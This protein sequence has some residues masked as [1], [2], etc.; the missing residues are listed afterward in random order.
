MKIFK[1]IKWRLQIWYGL[2]LVI[3]LAGFGI[4]AY[5]LERNRQFRQIDDE[6]HRRVGVLGNALHRP[7]PRRSNEGERPFDGPPPGRDSG[8]ETQPESSDSAPNNPRAPFPTKAVQDA[9]ERQFRRAPVQFHLPLEAAG[10]FDTGAT[11]GFYYVV[12]GRDENEIARSSNAPFDE[13]YRAESV[14]VAGRLN[15]FDPFPQWKDERQ[16]YNGE[17]FVYENF[18][19]NGIP[20]GQPFPP[21]MRGT[22]REIEIDTPPGERIL[23]GQNIIMELA[24][25][26]LIGVKLAGV[27]GIILF[28]GLAGGWWLVSH[29]IKPINEISA[30]AVKISAGDLSQR[31]N[32]AEAESELGQLAAVLNST[33]ARLETAFAQ[34]KQFASDA[35]HE[36]RTPVSVILTQTQTSLNRERDA[37]SYKQTVEACQRA[38]QRMRKLIE[39][40]LAL[41]RFDAGQEVLKRLSFDFSKTISDGAELVSPLA[42]ERGVK[43]SVEAEPIE[44]IGD[45]ERLAQVVTN[46]LTNAIQYNKADGEVRVK[47]ESQ[48]GLAV[49]TVADTGQGIAAKNLPQVFG[50]FFRA[51]SSR[52]GAEN[53]GLG[54]AITKAIVEAHGGTIE[55]A[56]EENAGTIFTVRLPI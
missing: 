30:T 40:L 53:A 2:I 15:H 47:L 39:S 23:V 38:A 52:T 43:I 5:Q 14:S 13:I 56:S 32:V 22:F 46:L 44:I 4:T 12:M 7:P 42:D 45:S 33:F 19:T 26:R 3:V 18:P 17:Q 48:N 27:G 37:A 28:I 49:L 35:A 6:L 16:K 29:A 1:S 24:E 21:Y 11:N 36:L 8:S 51:D 34:Q 20:S 54:L 50:R 31:I 41:A 55:V 25:L 9:L 10:L